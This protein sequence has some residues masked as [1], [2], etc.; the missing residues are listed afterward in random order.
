LPRPNNSFSN[1]QHPKYASIF[2][3]L[4]KAY[5]DKDGTHTILT[6]NEVASIYSHSPD[7]IYVSNTD[8]LD[9]NEYSFRSASACKEDHRMSLHHSMKMKF[10]LRYI[11]QRNKKKITTVN[12]EEMN[13][14]K[15]EIFLHS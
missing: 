13:Q 2:L 6:S 14:S 15:K 10:S 5:I 3:S 9:F 11:R 7:L 8:K 1:G 12:K 4:I